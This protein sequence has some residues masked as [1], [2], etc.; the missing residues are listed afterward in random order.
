MFN[1]RLLVNAIPIFLNEHS[2]PEYV[3]AGTVTG[4]LGGHL[5]SD[6][7][8]LGFEEMKMKGRLTYRQM[9]FLKGTGY[10]LLFGIFSAAYANVTSSRSAL[11]ELRKWETYWKQRV[12]Q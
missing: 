3:I 8:Q 1:S 4:V 11:R 10:G 2:W 7:K 5:F 6:R 9:S 12:N